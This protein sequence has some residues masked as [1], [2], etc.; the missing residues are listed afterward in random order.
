MMKINIHVISKTEN[1]FFYSVADDYLKRLSPYANVKLLELKEN[2]YDGDIRRGCKEDTRRLLSSV[3]EGLPIILDAGGKIFDSNEFSK[4]IVGLRD[5]DGGNICFLI[6]GAYG[7]DRELLKESSC[8]LLS[9]SPM[10]FTH[11]MARL[12][13]LEQLFRAFQIERGGEYHK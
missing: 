10:T 9:L 7:L 1:G 8:Q 13:L 2:S 6:G 5:F 3:K 12:L 4:Y 11:Q